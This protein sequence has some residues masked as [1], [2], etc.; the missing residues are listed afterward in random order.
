[1]TESEK[2]EKQKP[3]ISSKKLRPNLEVLA[4]WTAPERIWHPKSQQWFL[5]SA[6]IIL[7]FVF[8]LVRIEWYIGIIA[9]LA[10]MIMWFIQGYMAPLEVEHKIT[11]KGIYTNKKLYSWQDITYFWFAEKDDQ[12]ILHV[13]FPKESTYHRLTMLIPTEMEFDLFNILIDYAKYGE[14]AE[15]EYMFFSKYIYGEYYPISRY[16]LDLDQ[17]EAP[18]ANG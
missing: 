12:I 2:A 16:I 15:V 11:S 4:A 3:K 13:D 5:T 17:P 18:P 10:F 7:F 8:I 9:L 14:P 6:A 1:M